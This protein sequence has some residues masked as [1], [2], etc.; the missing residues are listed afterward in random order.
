MNNDTHQNLSW[1]IMIFRIIFDIV[2][3][4]EFHYLT[5]TAIDQEI[6]VK[7]Q[8]T[9]SVH[10]GEELQPLH[11]KCNVVKYQREQSCIL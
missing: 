10:T 9:G 4:L 3:K 8:Q 5:V 11:P 2:Y 6:E 7:I 1:Y